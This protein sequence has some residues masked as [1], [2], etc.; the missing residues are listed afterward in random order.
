MG[1]SWTFNDFGQTFQNPN[2]PE[3]HLYFPVLFNGFN[4]NGQIDIVVLVSGGLIQVLWFR[5]FHWN[6]FLKSLSR[7]VASQVGAQ[8]VIIH[9]ISGID[10][11]IELRVA[12]VMFLRWSRRLVAA[13]TTMGHGSVGSPSA[14]GHGDDAGEKKLLLLSVLQVISDFLGI[15]PLIQYFIRQRDPLGFA[16]SFELSV[17]LFHLEI[18]VSKWNLEFCELG[19]ALAVKLDHFP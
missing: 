14:V 11:A 16:S 8:E 10:A 18:G 5:S 13:R 4:I 7:Q 15:A 3:N 6:P 2:S 1:I 19:D 17:K 9:D 12:P